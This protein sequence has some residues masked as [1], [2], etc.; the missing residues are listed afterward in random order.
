MLSGQTMPMPIAGAFTN[1]L[2]LPPKKCKASRNRSL[3]PHPPDIPLFRCHDP[4]NNPFTV[5]YLDLFM[6]KIQSLV[7]IDLFG[8]K[9]ENAQT[10]LLPL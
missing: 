8:H 2:C 9:N 7:T 5:T 1:A 3:Y 6:T 10:I 4:F